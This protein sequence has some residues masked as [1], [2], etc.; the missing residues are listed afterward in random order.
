MLYYVCYGRKIF[1]IPMLKDDAV[2]YAAL[3]AGSNLVSYDNPTK[4]NVVSEFET[5]NWQTLTNQG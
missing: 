3:L 5:R 2:I 4:F 1:S